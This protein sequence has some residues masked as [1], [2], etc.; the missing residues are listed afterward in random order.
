MHQDQPVPPIS[1]HRVVSLDFIA[2]SGGFAVRVVRG[3][4][5]PHRGWNPRTNDIKKTELLLRELRVDQ[6]DNFG[7]HLHDLLVDVDI[8]SDSPALLL[9]LDQLLPPCN[10]VWGH[11]SRPRTHRVYQTRLAFDPGDHKIL[12]QLQR[13]DET[14]VEFRGGPP[15]RGKYSILPGSIHP[16]NEEYLWSDLK[17]A[18]STPTVATIVVLIRA[19]RLAGAIAVLAPYWTE[20]LRNDLVMALSGFLHR[21]SKIAEQLGNDED[22]FRVDKVLAERFLKVL[23]SVTGDDKADL[24]SRMKTFEATW[25]KADQ[26]VAVTGATRIAEL[27]GDQLLIRKLYTLLTDSAEIAAIDEFTDRFAIWSGPGVIIDMDTSGDKRPFM[28]RTQF[29]DSF[30]HQFV[31]TGEKRQLIAD[32]IYRLPTTLRLAGPT[33]EPGA[34]KLVDTEAGRKVN[35]WRGFVVEPHTEPVEAPEIDPFLNYLHDIALS[36]AYEIRL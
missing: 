19:V 29:K 36:R 10:H 25:K 8:D 28:T 21:T 3:Q 30:G 5:G 17:K 16:S 15:E 11:A 22:V 12:D 2:A 26:D 20:G 6:T 27:T 7:I 14:K 1:A 18:R 13:W 9:A 35:R 31:N 4:K 33:F 24:G 23:F 34:P 32:L